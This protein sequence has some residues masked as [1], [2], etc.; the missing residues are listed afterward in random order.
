MYSLRLLSIFACLLL[1][2]D[3]RVFPRAD[4]VHQAKR[5]AA[6]AVDLDRLLEQLK[7]SSEKVRTAAA[8]RLKEIQTENLNISA[9]AGS[10][11]LRAAAQPAAF[12]KP[13]PAE[14][15]ADLVD[16]LVGHPR[17]E[18]IPIVVR[19]FDRFSEPGRASALLLITQIESREAAEAYMKIFKTYGKSGKIVHAAAEPLKSKPRYPE[20]FFPELLNYATDPKLSFELYQLCLEYCEADLLKPEV[21]APFTDQVLESYRIQARELWPGQKREGI[22]WMWEE[23]YLASRNEAS[24][25]LDLFG[26]FPPDKV[27]EELQRALRYRDPRL[28][29]FGISSLLRLGKEV[30][31][32]SIE[33]AAAYAEVR[34][35]LFATLQKI[36]KENLFPKKYRTQEAFAES[37]M[38]DWLAHPAEL[39]RVPD[40]IELMKVVSMDLGGQEGVCDY[41]VFRFRTLP[42][43]EAAKE[44]WLAG[45]SGP[46]RQKETP[47]I[48]ALGHTFSAFEKW[49]SKSPEEH[50]NRIRQLI[51]QQLKNQPKEGEPE[52]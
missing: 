5:P 47:T 45:V 11:I 52:K 35:Y 40:E 22:A 44:G 3:H 39:A 7:S 49:E 31:T 14:I 27:V 48:N 29:F 50:L 23:Q 13:D 8:N 24:M 26:Y 17:P 20:I 12:D 21:L 43:H 36:G 33:S 30:D 34:N 4:A 2:P 16:L 37:N 41:Y 32:K 15:S 42:P 46:F 1:L 10:K 28:K 6:K 38:V 9:Q 25:L 18:Y 19:L 51:E